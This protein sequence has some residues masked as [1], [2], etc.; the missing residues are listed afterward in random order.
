[1]ARGLIENR[2]ELETLFAELA[3][4]LA[5]LGTVAQVVM[6]G[7]GWMLWHSRRQSTRDVDSA[8]TLGPRVASAVEKVAGRFGLSNS[9]LN[10]S[11]AAFWPANAKYDD[12]EVVYRHPNLEVLT[13]D[14]EVI[15]MM[16]LN[17][18]DPQDREDLISLWPLCRFGDSETA[19][20]G[21]R[22]AYPHA[23][24]DE[25]LADY[26]AGVADDAGS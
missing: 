7:G 14:P 15:F 21:F 5:K 26:I 23:P 17:R 20:A 6:V 9:W 13:P 3:D 11:A 25:Y 16:K 4:E 10:D 24:H 22:A 12:C 8:R 1:M 19:A 2:A 18:A